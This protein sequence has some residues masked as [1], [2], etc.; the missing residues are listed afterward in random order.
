MTLTQRFVTGQDGYVASAAPAVIGRR[1]LNRRPLVRDLDRRAIAGEP[2][3][4]SITGL[5][6]DAMQGKLVTS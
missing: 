5:T 2:I 1:D 4:S 3:D 6:G